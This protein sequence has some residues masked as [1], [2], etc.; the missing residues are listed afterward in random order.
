[1]KTK[2]LTLHD[3]IVIKKNMGQYWVSTQG[4]TLLCGLRLPAEPPRG[5]GKNGCKN[6][7][8]EA[9]DIVVGDR[10]AINQYPDGSALICKVQPRVN[11]LARRAAPPNP[12]R[13]RRPPS[14]SS[15]PIS[16][17]WWR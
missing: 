3:G 14:R 8:R 15:R 1:M 9:A 10:V 2:N 12:N 5:N 7:H 16:I 13:A 17:N 11:R 4:E 6:R